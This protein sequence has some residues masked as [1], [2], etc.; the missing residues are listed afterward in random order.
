MQ[1]GDG[2][3]AKAEGRMQKRKS[4]TIRLG[5][6]CLRTATR[7]DREC[8]LNPQVSAFAGGHGATGDARATAVT[9]FCGAINLAFECGFPKLSDRFSNYAHELF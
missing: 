7:R 1:I 4:R 5:Q 8:R 2:Q 3:R 9:Q 6:G